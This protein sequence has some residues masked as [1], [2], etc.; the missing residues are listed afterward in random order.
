MQDLEATLSADLVP[1]V[2]GWLSSAN[3]KGSIMC[4][5]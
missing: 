5:I 1:G 2:E 4:Y 3:P